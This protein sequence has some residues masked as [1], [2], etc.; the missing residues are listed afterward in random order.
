[1]H[2]SAQSL[3]SVG[4]KQV[5]TQLA[6]VT[7][8]GAHGKAPHKPVTKEQCEQVR[9][10]VLEELSASDKGKANMKRQGSRPLSKGKYSRLD[11]DISS[12]QR[13]SATY[14]DE[15]ADTA[16]YQAWRS[17]FDLTSYK[18]AVAQLIT[19]NAFMAE[20]QAR[21]VPVIVEYDA[22][23]TRYF[24]RLH[25]LEVICGGILQCYIRGSRPHVLQL[26]ASP[27]TELKSCTP[28][29]TWK[30]PLLFCL[31]CFMTTL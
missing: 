15:P 6:T 13:D 24:Y 29:N 28:T 26:I 8:G 31:S 18:S 9:D 14:C 25:L 4:M 30:S 19:D 11:A 2:D 12:M 16:D 21:I 27:K 3:L 22:F 20:L 10:T 17:N 5:Q 7:N 1:M 23:W